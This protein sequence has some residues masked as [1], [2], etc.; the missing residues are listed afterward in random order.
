VATTATPLASASHH[1]TSSPASTSPTVGDVVL[2]SDDGVVTITIPHATE[3]DYAGTRISQFPTQSRF[4]GW[5]ADVGGSVGYDIQPPLT[6]VDA[7]VTWRTPFEEGRADYL[8][9]AKN[10]PNGS[11]SWLSD[12]TTT[13]DQTAGE[14]VTQGH[15]SNVAS[16]VAVRGGTAYFVPSQPNLTLSVGSTTN[17]HRAVAPAVLVH[18]FGGFQF[19]P[20]ATADRDVVE[21][22]VDD[23]AGLIGFRCVSPGTSAIRIDY[24]DVFG[25]LTVSE[26]LPA[27]MPG[28]DLEYAATVA[29]VANPTLNVHTC[30]QFIRAPF[31]GH[32]HRLVAE[33]LYEGDDVVQTTLSASQVQSGLP[34]SG[35]LEELGPNHWRGSFPFDYG[36][37][38]VSLDALQAITSDGVVHEELASLLAALGG[39]FWNP[40]D[41]PWP[42]GF[43]LGDGC[44]S[45]DLLPGSS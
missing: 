9:L 37:G 6:D 27:Q 28:V 25:W 7:T 26:P 41:I 36:D 19:H 1:A 16:I 39:P 14:V 3:S 35:S 12:T 13:F 21:P 5:D 17:V 32:N 2:K 30:L 10:T 11:W 44:N 33:V 18:P 23:A 29:C 43:H 24:P 40:I 22:V 45:V 4:H 34:L 31:E 42:N 8:A 15:A 20:T 38:S